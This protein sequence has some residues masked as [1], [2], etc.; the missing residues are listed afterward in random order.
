MAADN[1][2]LQELGEQAPEPVRLLG[3]T[4]KEAPYKVPEGYFRN[5]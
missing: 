1:D 5:A 4:K 3:N 2:I